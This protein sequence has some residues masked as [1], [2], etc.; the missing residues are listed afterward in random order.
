MFI[1]GKVKNK[2]NKLIDG[3]EV[4]VAVIDQFNTVV[5]EKRVLVVPTQQGSL[6][7]AKRSP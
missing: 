4:N 6:G 3:L 5:K 1:V 2:G 7:P